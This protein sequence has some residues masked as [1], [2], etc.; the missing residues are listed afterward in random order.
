MCGTWQNIGQVKALPILQM[1]W[2]LFTAL[3]HWN[4]HILENLFCVLTK[5]GMTSS[6]SCSHQIPV[7]II[8]SN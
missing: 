6:T 5:A 7:K 1:Q 2:L 4:M 3:V 8:Y